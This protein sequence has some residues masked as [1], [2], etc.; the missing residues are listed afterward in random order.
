MLSTERRTVAFQGNSHLSCIKYSFLKAGMMCPDCVLV[1]A[2][3]RT[4]IKPHLPIFCLLSSIHFAMNIHQ[5]SEAKYCHQ[6]IWGRDY[7]M[8]CRHDKAPDASLF[9]SLRLCDR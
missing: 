3:N 8:S 6:F 5:N 7:I 4:H 1:T 9:I 2:V